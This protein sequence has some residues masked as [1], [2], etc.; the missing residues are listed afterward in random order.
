MYP[1]YDRY[2]YQRH[3]SFAGVI[4]LG[5]LSTLGSGCGGGGG[6]GGGNGELTYSGNTNPAVITPGNATML[7]AS[8]IGGDVV[9]DTINSPTAVVTSSSPQQSIGV[10]NMVNRLRHSLKLTQINDDSF[11]QS[12]SVAAVMVDE[13]V[14]CTDGGIF[15][16]SGDLNNAG[17]GVLNI[18]FENC[19]EGGATLNGSGTF[20]IDAFDMGYFEVT[21]GTMSFTRLTMSG[22]GCDMTI[23][24]SMRFEM[25][26]PSNFE[27]ITT[28][29]VIQ[30]IFCGRMGKAE[31]YVIETIYDN[32]LF[33]SSYTSLI[34]GRLYDSVHGYIDITTPSALG[35]IDLSIEIPNVGGQLLLTGAANARAQMEVLAQNKALLELDL[36]NDTVYEVSGELPWEVL[37]VAGTN[38]DDTDGDGIPDIWETNNGMNSEDYSDSETHSDNDG[39]SNREEYAAGTNPVD[40]D[41][42]ADSLPDGWELSNSLN[43][44]DPS[45]AGLDADGDGKTNLEEF[46]AGSDPNFPAEWLDF[47]VVDAE[48]SASLETIVMV[49]TGPN[50]LYLYDTSTSLQ[51]QVDLPLVPSSVSISPDGLFAAVGHD[52]WISYIDLSNELLVDSFAVSTDVFDVVLDGNGFIHAF[53]RTDQWETIR[54]IEIETSIETLHTG[55]SI[56]AGTRARLHPNGSWVYGAD[57]GL[58][59]SDIEKYDISVNPVTYLYDSPYHGDYAMCGDLWFSEDGVRIFTRCGNVFR[60]SAVPAQDMIYNGS[61]ENI[62]QTTFVDHS[63]EAGLVAAIPYS[64]F[65]TN[66]DTI[67]SLFNYD[68]LTHNSS[69]TLPTF[70]VGS[71]SYS[72]HGKFVFFNSNGTRHFVIVQADPASGALNDYA[73]AFYQ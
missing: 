52:G 71:T 32:I 4:I 33:P 63:L 57:N 20:R 69:V 8:V 40:S 72:T 9:A 54:T 70:T 2:K 47:Q 3:F 16:L 29:M 58:S 26:I 34:S 51:T 7:V 73:I 61:L 13:V 30:N 42:D 44:L 36:D 1:S 18:S 6:G 11:D 28:N 27:R 22:P 67:L 64:F 41:T 48:Y 10:T 12:P 19:Q 15:R 21:D 14:L 55:S 38:P 39:L 53:P 68:F 56:R 49:A 23:S 24:G 31:N 66:A 50:R 62:S 35:Y 46:L 37:I 45:D 60:T 65:D 5:I 43:P 17:T 59:P 25:I